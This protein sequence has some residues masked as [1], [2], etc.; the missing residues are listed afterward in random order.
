MRRHRRRTIIAFHNALITPLKAS[1]FMPVS[2]YQRDRLRA[3][4]GPLGDNAPRGRARVNVD[5]CFATLARKDKKGSF[6]LQK[7]DKRVTAPL[8]A[9]RRGRERVR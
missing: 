7:R 5:Q 9:L 4:H 1:C 6:G 8:N 2:T 3:D